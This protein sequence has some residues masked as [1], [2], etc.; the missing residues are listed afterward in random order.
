MQDAFGRAA[1]PKATNG[2][3]AA[4]S[5]NLENYGT[6]VADLDPLRVPTLNG[7]TDVQWSAQ[8]SSDAQTINS[9]SV[10]YDGSDGRMHTANVTRGTNGDFTVSVDGYKMTNGVLTTAGEGFAQNG[11]MDVNVFREGATV[12]NA[13]LLATTNTPDIQQYPGL[14]DDLSTMARAVY[15]ETNYAPLMANATAR[16]GM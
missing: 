14:A 9:Y 4:A 3:D 7:A 10:I 11:S 2:P 1:V 15:P 16:A 6:P 5:V 8:A 12:L 13:S